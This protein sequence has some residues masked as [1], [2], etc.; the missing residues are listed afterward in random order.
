MRGGVEARPRDSLEQP[1]IPPGHV[2]MSSREADWLTIET[3]A[4]GTYYSPPKRH[5]IL[6]KESFDIRIALGQ[7][8]GGDHRAA[9]SGNYYLLVQETDPRQPRT[10][11]LDDQGS[12]VSILASAGPWRGRPAAWRWSF[13]SKAQAAKRVVNG[14][15][16]TL[17]PWNSGA[18]DFGS[19]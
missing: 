6:A 1:V 4:D 12:T 3:P 10:Q 2:P 14:E 7:K 5:Q 17:E 19:R 16:V 8:K 18:L 15:P 9:Q 11:G 13:G